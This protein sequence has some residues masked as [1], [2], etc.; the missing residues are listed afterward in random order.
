M[1]FHVDPFPNDLDPSVKMRIGSKSLLG[2]HS[3]LIKRTNINIFRSLLSTDRDAAADRG[4]WIN[5]SRINKKEQRYF[6]FL[7]IILPLSC[8]V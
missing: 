5:K 1:H 3:F 7:I 6:M 2:D 4:E 8:R